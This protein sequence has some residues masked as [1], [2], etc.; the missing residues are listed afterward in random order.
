MDDNSIKRFGP[1]HVFAQSTPIWAVDDKIALRALGE[2]RYQK[3]YNYKSIQDHGGILTFGSDFPVE[4]TL[5]LNALNN[6][7]AGITRQPLGKADGTAGIFK[8]ECLTL[9]DMI[10]AY[11]VNGARQLGLDDEVG[12]IEVGKK[13]DLVLLNHNLF[14]IEPHQIHQTKIL[15]TMMDGRV[16]YHRD[17]KVWLWERFQ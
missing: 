9:E 13:A 8:E 6:I 1:L 4:F 11:T 5:G 2:E 14:D 7:E 3:N 12:T 17:I 15:Y 16:V 10:R